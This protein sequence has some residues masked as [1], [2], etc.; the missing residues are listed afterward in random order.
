MHGQYDPTLHRFTREWSPIPACDQQTFSQR[1]MWSTGN[2]WRKHSCWRLKYQVLCVDL[3]LPNIFQY[4]PVI[5]QTT[6][7]VVE[8]PGFSVSAGLLML[9]GFFNWI[10]SGV[11]SC[12]V[13]VQDHE[14]ADSVRAQT[15]GVGVLFVSPDLPIPAAQGT[16][17]C[18]SQ[19]RHQR[20]FWDVQTSGQTNA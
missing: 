13:Q 1:K 19:C 7:F 20:V 8:F 18:C 5:R 4:N 11:V 16:T 14:S 6:K 9:L 15:R 2:R 12:G 10:F 3:W 17:S